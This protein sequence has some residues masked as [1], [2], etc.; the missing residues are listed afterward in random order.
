MTWELSLFYLVGCGQ[1]T[2]ASPCRQAFTLVEMLVV[3]AIIAI[4]AALLMPSLQQAMASAKSLSCVNQLKQHGS[5]VTQYV[6]DNGGFM[7]VSSY[8]PAVADSG[9][10]YIDQKGGTRTFELYWA[11]LIYQ[12]LKEPRLYTC[13]NKTPVNSGGMYRNQYGVNIGQGAQVDQYSGALQPGNAG[14]KVNRYSQLAK[15]SALLLILD[16]VSDKESSL[17]DDWG[18]GLYR[19][20]I[21]SEDIGR[22]YLH[23]SGFNTVFCDGHA[24]WMNPLSAQDTQFW[25]RR[26]Y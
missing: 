16:R 12:Y 8:Y 13:P 18:S 1:R 15:P 25:Y 26:G 3:I 23:G 19:Y 2:A 24:A 9:I 21:V 14:N 6:G 20:Q 17:Y 5:A 4:L 11:A 22:F 10:T 7:P